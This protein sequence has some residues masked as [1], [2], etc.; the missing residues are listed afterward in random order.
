MFRLC[1]LLAYVSSLKGNPIRQKFGFDSGYSDSQQ[2]H[3]S[4][5][6]QKLIPDEKLNLSIQTQIYIQTSWFATFYLL[7]WLQNIEPT[8]IV[9]WNTFDKYEK[10]KNLEIHGEKKKTQEPT[11][12]CV[13]L[14]IWK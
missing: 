10:K 5:T 3:S 14:K 11:V 2:F 13:D 9:C 8:L 6:Q 12:G 7:L 1:C 4:K